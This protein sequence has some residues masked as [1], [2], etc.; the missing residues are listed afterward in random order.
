MNIFKNKH[1][2][3][4]MVVAPILAIIAY[5]GTDKLVGEKPHAAKA[6]QVYELIARSNCRYTSG[7][8]TLKNGNF[9]LDLEFQ[10]PEKIV[11]IKAS[12]PLQG[13]K[14]GFDDGTPIELLESDD[15]QTYWQVSVDATLLESDTFQLVVKAN[16][17][18][19]FAENALEFK[20]RKTLVDK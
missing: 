17:A 14:I 15:T 16:D 3:A 6:G 20:Q 13:A 18:L 9:L 10:E 11:T 2:L 4:A 8:C 12:H 19:Y 1:V 7:V 5:V